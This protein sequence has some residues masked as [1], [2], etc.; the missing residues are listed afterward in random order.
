MILNSRRSPIWSEFNGFD[1]ITTHF[2]SVRTEDDFSA[3]R[4]IREDELSPFSYALL[5]ALI[6][7]IFPTSG[8]RRPTSG[9][10]LPTIV[11]F[12][13]TSVL[14][15][16]ISG[17]LTS[18]D[19]SSRTRRAETEARALSSFYPPLVWRTNPLIFLASNLLSS[20]PQTSSD[21]SD[22]SSKSED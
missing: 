9:L 22:R 6:F 21:L 7:R 13:L 5:F 20:L 11:P 16:L 4:V 15:H 8:F 14:R 10:C 2:F 18:S 17:P 12:G 19:L 3:L 1:K